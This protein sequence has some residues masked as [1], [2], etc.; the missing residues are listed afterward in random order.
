[1]FGQERLE[2]LLNQFADLSITKLAQRIIAE[3]E[4]FQEEQAD[5]ITLV[6]L[7]KT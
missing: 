2:R 1:M 7:R 5:D 6:I 3:V 4:A